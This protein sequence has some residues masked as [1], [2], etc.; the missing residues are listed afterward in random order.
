MAIFLSFC[1]SILTRRSSSSFPRRFSL[2]L[3]RDLLLLLSRDLSWRE[4]RNYVNQLSKIQGNNLWQVCM[5]SLS[6]SFFLSL[7][8]FL[9]ILRIIIFLHQ[10]WSCLTTSR[11]TWAAN[12]I[13]FSNI[14]DKS[15]ERRIQ[16]SEITY[17]LKRF[18]PFD[19]QLTVFV[20]LRLQFLKRDHKNP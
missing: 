14:R 12:L 2:C 8:A 9:F 15:I 3:S 20:T 18:S 10:I 7:S 17:H 13:F 6:L 16:I 11:L 4:I 5:I 19:C 1:L